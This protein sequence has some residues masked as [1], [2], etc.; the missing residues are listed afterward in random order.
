MARWKS[1]GASISFSAI[2]LSTGGFAVASGLDHIAEV[3]ENFKITDEN[4]AYL[5]SLDAP[6]GGKLFNPDFLE[7]L[8]NLKLSVDIDAVREGTV[9]FPN[10][11]F[12]RVIGPVLQ[13]QLLE[14]QLLN[15][16]NF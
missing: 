6:G 12:V 8:R 11:P 2:L 3:V 1:R 16:V 13:C 15:C 7:Y 4:I 10:D 9:V 5:A 14:T